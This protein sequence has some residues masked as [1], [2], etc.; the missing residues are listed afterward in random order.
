LEE[1]ICRSPYDPR[2]MHCDALLLP[3]SF[4]SSGGNLQ[5]SINDNLRR[6]RSGGL[7]SVQLQA[8]SGSCHC[9][10]L[11]IF[12]FQT[13]SSV[14][15]LSPWLFTGRTFSEYFPIFPLSFLQI[16]SPYLEDKFAA[17]LLDVFL[18]YFPLHCC[19]GCFF[20]DC[21]EIPWLAQIPS[22]SS[23]HAVNVS[24]PGPPSE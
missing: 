15:P 2:L 7:A 10:P 22:F 12:F 21:C 3:S 16:V 11:T 18:H 19:L 9:Y 13:N 6:F 17:A 8:F 4:P 5:G 14:T 24:P 20:L 1:S 23:P